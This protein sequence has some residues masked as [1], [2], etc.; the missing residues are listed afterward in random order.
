M[1]I[2]LEDPQL[3]E[4]VTI[5]IDSSEIRSIDAEVLAKALLLQIRNRVSLGAAVSK[6]PTVEAGFTRAVQA[7]ENAWRGIAD[8]F[9]MLSSREVAERIG[10]K[11]SNRN[12][13]SDLRKRGQL[14]GVNRLNSY[15]YPGF[16]FTAEGT[17]RPVIP[18][19]ITTMN[20][21]GWTE[22]SLV[23]WLCSPSGRFSGMRPVD[24]LDDPAL[25]AKARD[26][27]Q[28]DW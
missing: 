15:K 18:E 12:L 8:E 6:L 23:L 16:Q 10:S 11:S 1:K 21:S 17:V 7:T 5:E 25:V 13:A 22:P 24:L 28:T 3:V 19:L 2:T 9:G 26:M 14:L 27:M 20:E 4:V